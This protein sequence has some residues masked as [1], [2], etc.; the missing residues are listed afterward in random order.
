MAFISALLSLY[1]PFLTGRAVDCILGPGRVDFRGAVRVMVLIALCASFT[2]LAQYIM[3]ILNNKIACGVVRDMRD[4]AFKKIGKLPLSYLDDHPYGDILSRV[5]SD[6]D[7]FSDGLIMGFSQFFTGIVTIFGTLFFMLM[8]DLKMGLIVI[9][10]TP[11]SIFVAKFI[12]VHTYRHALTQAKVRG[13]ETSFVNEMV[14]GSMVIKAFNREER[15]IKDFNEINEELRDASLKAT[16]F[17]SLTNPSTRFVNNTVYAVIAIAGGFGALKG[18]M[19]VG[20]LTSF[21]GYAREYTKPF[22][23]ITGVVTELQNALA[24]AERLIDFIEEEEEEPDSEDALTLFGCSGEIDVDSISFSYTEDKELI[25]DFSLNVKPGQHIAI[26]GPTGCGK[27][28]LINLLMR[29]Y[30]VKEGSISVDGKDIRKVTRRSL[31]DSFGMVLQD[32][33]LKSGTIRENLIMGDPSVSEEEMVAAAKDCHAH[34]FI[35]KLPQGYDTVIS[36]DGGSLSAGQKQL[37]CI[38]RAM[39]SKPSMLILDEATSNIDTRTEVKIQEAFHR[40]MDGKTGFIV[41]HRLSTIREADLILVMKDGNIIEQGN[42]EEL[43]SRKGFYHELY[44]S[45]FAGNAT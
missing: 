32:T 38:T 36:E 45:Q 33:W 30:D 31:R 18:L 20:E 15:V 13:K 8:I 17:S 37:L 29:F 34:S 22:N 24:C 11:L 19:T 21:L 27:T 5:I 25:R 4:A 14:G 28:T 1:I 6:A 39:L 10:L 12:A 41:A 7:Q 40:I 26:A 43:L 16:F 2:S 35:M 23:E 3:N 9:L 42:H 44:Q